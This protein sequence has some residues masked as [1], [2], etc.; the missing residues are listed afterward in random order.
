MSHPGAGGARG[1]PVDRIVGIAEGGLR[2]DVF[3][4]RQPEFGSR[5]RAKDWV[6]LGHV[7]V[8]GE[9]A[10]PSQVVATGSVV[11][12]DALPQSKELGDEEFARVPLR[13]LHE[14]QEL[15]V[16]DK[17]PGLP[18]HPQEGQAV[19][20]TLSVASLA[21]HRCGELPRLAG[22]DR[23]GIVHRLDKDTSG[24]MV[25][26]RT[27]AAFHALQAQFRG[28][29]V[30]KEYRALCWGES[31]FDSDYIDRRLATQKGNVER[32]VVVEHGGRPARTY[33]E[34]LERLAGLT[35]FRCLPRSGRTHQIR[36]HL[37]SIG[38]P[39]VGDQLYRT[40][41][42]AHCALPPGAPDPRRHC[43]HA[44]R[45]EFAHPSTGQPVAFEAPIP[46]DLE[47]LLS[48]LRRR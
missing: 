26:A 46:A 37:A 14:D 20:S 32:V 39:L 2:L 35:W 45:L 42:S 24:V 41:Q 19:L 5:T 15:L 3:L 43:L 6:D 18:A 29:L 44:F 27:E 10:R 36:V 12:F 40:R 16:V 28:R 25:L 9:M 31:R 7:R 30:Q 8:D 1:E 38:H 22:L 33:Y 34:V 17:P 21:L 23:P 4:A 13:V 47:A 48:W 11:Q